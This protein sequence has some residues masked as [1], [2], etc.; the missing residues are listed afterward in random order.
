VNVFD[1]DARLS[2]IADAYYAVPLGELGGVIASLRRHGVH[3][4]VLAGT[5]NK[6]TALATVKPDAT[7][8][9]AAF[10]LM[11]RLDASLL[12]VLIG[13][14]EEEGFAV[15]N[16]ALFCGD[17]VPDAG[18]LSRRQPSAGEQ[19]DIRLGLIMARGIAGLDIG[20][21]VAI[22][23]GVVVAVEAAEGT[24]AMIRRAGALASGV[25]VVKVSRPR[26]DPRFD[27]PVVGPQ[28]VEAMVASGG[29]AL[30]I[31]AGRTIL[32][33]RDRLVAAADAAGIAVVSC[34]P[35]DVG[36]DAVDAGPDPWPPVRPF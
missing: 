35:V 31:E 33:E 4:V 18:V 14:L 11:D 1:G 8:M 15:V 34:D 17:L 20:Q 29:T 19:R 30:A 9:R 16:Q 23:R 32:L 36:P 25:V 27:L 12:S 13:I 21:S 3:D 10:R 24:D 26:Q 22:R 6:L 5:V 2:E 28:T 7:A